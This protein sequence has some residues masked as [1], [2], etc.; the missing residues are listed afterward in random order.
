MSCECSYLLKNLTPA[1]AAERSEEKEKNNDSQFIILPMP[2]N[3]YH[4]EKNTSDRSRKTLEKKVTFSNGASR[5]LLMLKPFNLDLANL[6][7]EETAIHSQS[8]QK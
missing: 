6:F 8:G 5:T 3:L 4:V 2:P 1:E 7:S